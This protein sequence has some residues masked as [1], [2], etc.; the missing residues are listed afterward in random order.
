MGRGL[1]TLRLPAGDEIAEQLE[2]VRTSEIP[3]MVVTGGW[4]HA[5]DAIGRLA[6]EAGRGQHVVIASNHHFP[7]AVSDEFND[8]LN[9]FMLEADTKA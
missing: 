4:S 3:F 7:Q 8:R 5:F 6:A 1:K 2:V 9:S